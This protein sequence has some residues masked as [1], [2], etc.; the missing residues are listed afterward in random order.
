MS[1]PE[2]ESSPIV[3]SIGDDLEGSMTTGD[4]QLEKGAYLSVEVIRRSGIW[5]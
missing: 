4:W 1:L 3:K 5:R 2:S